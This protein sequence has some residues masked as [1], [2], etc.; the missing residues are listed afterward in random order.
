[1]NKLCPAMVYGAVAVPREF[2]PLFQK[3]PAEIDVA[4]YES[5]RPFG[6]GRRF[7]YKPPTA[8]ERAM[9]ALADRLRRLADEIDPDGACW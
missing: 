3:W 1:M 8:K 6:S 9:S 5:I 2:A 4:A 7:K